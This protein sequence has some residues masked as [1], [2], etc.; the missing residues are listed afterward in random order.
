L[1]KS[2][3][4]RGTRIMT[5]EFSKPDVIDDIIYP[6][7]ARM[8][9]S[10]RVQLEDNGFS[11]AGPNGSLCEDQGSIVL[12]I[13]LSIHQLPRIEKRLGPTVGMAE[14]SRKFLEKHSGSHPYIE[15]D[16]WCVDAPRRFCRAEDLVRHIVRENPQGMLPSHVAKAIRRGWKLKT[17]DE[18]I[19]AAG[20]GTRLLLT[21]H[22]EPLFP[23][24]VE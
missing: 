8:Q 16:R 15:E 9:K 2:L 22:F 17:D 3:R 20:P 18:A 23:W 13:E 11:L 10:L 7:L 14:H 21:E 5:I 19:D 24:Q 12:L 6:Q 1:R 4:G